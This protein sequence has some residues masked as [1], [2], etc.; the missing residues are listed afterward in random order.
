MV[1]G[2]KHAFKAFERTQ[3]ARK[4]TMII[5]SRIIPIVWRVLVAMVPKTDFDFW[6]LDFDLF[7][8]KTLC[9]KLSGLHNQVSTPLEVLI[10]V[11]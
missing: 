1:S 9:F 7:Q 11:H 8:R 6:G 2:Y 4:T 10:Q 3:Y 5:I